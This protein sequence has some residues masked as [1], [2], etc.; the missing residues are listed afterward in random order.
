MGAEVPDEAAPQQ[1]DAAEPKALTE[2]KA[3]S[4]QRAFRGSGMAEVPVVDLPL[5]P[6]SRKDIV[7]MFLETHSDRPNLTERAWQSLDDCESS[8]EVLVGLRGI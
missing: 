7:N 6:R 3:L 4:L 2:P 5:C 8:P 1:L